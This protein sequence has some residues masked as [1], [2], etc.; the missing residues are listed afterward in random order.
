MSGE[1]GG[2]AELN[3][4]RNMLHNMGKVVRDMGKVVRNT[5]RN[6]NILHNMI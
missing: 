1:E 3:V 4:G 5:L 2:G 6:I